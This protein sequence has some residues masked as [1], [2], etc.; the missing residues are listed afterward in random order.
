MSETLIGAG[1]LACIG[2]YLFINLR[3]KKENKKPGER[4]VFST[5]FLVIAFALFL[6]STFLIGKSAI[7]N[8]DYCSILPS[9]TTVVGDTT[10]IE[11]TRE[12]FVNESETATGLFTLSTYLI[13]ISSIFLLL[14]MIWAA[15]QMIK[16]VWDEYSGKKF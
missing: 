6:F 10:L 13:I 4:D 3:P 11:Y 1:I 15:W 9:N 7:D 14:L 5:G 12:C 2:V 8:Q 16:D